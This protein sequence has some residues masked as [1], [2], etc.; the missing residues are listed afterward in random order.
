MTNT[1]PLE[2]LDP[3]MPVGGEIWHAYQAALSTYVIFAREAV[4][5]S[6]FG[7][8]APVVTDAGS[9]TKVDGMRQ[10]LFDRA[11]ERN[12]DVSLVG[13]EVLSMFIGSN[14][15]MMKL[16]EQVLGDFENFAQLVLQRMSGQENQ[17]GGEFDENVDAPA[18]EEGES[19][20]QDG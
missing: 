20:E 2:R 12:L 17:D 14:V 3:D 4:P 11:L 16:L 7:P 1:V 6:E 9:E 13:A 8:G 19:D 18:P 10:D 5:P 15:P